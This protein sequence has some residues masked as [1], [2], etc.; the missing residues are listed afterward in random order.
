MVE[1][2]NIKGTHASRGSDTRVRVFWSGSTITSMIES[3]KYAP[4]CPGPPYPSRTNAY[5]GS[6][7]VSAGTGA[8]LWGPSA[9]G[10]AI[11]TESAPTF[12]L[13]S[14]VRVG[15]RVACDRA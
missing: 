11:E 4:S 8:V 14:T 15:T 6:V 3:V 12:V 9:V 13:T 5:R 1:L 10:A 2:L 7:V